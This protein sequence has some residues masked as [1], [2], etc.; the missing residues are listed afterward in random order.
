MKRVIGVIGVVLAISG[1][2]GAPGDE[3]SPAA[4]DPAAEAHVTRTIVRIGPAGDPEVSTEEISVTQQRAEIAARAAFVREREEAA[5]NGTLP[6]TVEIARDTGCSTS[7]LWMFDQPGQSGNE[8][9]FN[10]SGPTRLSLYFRAYPCDPIDAWC[11]HNALTWQGT[12][13]YAATRSYWAGTNGGNFSFNPYTTAEYFSPWQRVDD[14]TLNAQ[15]A[16]TLYLQP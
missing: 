2:G 12:T 7:S 13:L 9:C 8:I 5:K 6:R 4:A 1:C 10:G 3:A 11:R 16:D 15:L 14:T